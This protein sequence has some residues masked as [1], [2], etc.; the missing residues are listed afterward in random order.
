L[1]EPLDR[2]G[3]VDGEVHL[4]LGLAYEATGRLVEATDRAERSCAI[5]EHPTTLLLLA[6]LAR[7]TGATEEALRFCDR[8]ARTPDAAP[9][10]WLLRV[11]LLEEAGR[12]AEARSALEPLL[13]RHRSSPGGLPLAVRIEEAKLLVQEGL[14]RD[15]V[16]RIDEILA[17][18]GAGDELR[19]SMLYLKAKALDRCAAYDEAMEC[20]MRANDIGRIAFDPQ[21]YAEQVDA[22]MDNW[23]ADRMRRFPRSA[24]H[25]ER[26]VFVAGMPRSGTTLLDQIIDAHPMAAGVGELSSIEH[27]ALRLSSAYRHEL[28]APDCLGPFASPDALTAI[29]AEYADICA[30]KAPNAR[31]IVNKAL[32]NNRLVGLLAMLF[33]R[34]KV[35]HAIRDP[36]DVAVSCLMGGFNNALYPWTTRLDWVASAWE[37]SMRLMEH[38]KRVLDIEILEVRYERLVTHP[39][40]EFPRIVSFLGL[41]WDEQCRRFHESRRT[42]RTL[43]YDQ[44]N[45]P[46]Y[47]TSAGR[48]QRYA[49]HLEGMAWPAYG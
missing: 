39:D 9:P 36:R 38:W 24:C 4:L 21:I 12:T 44:V 23:S 29:A 32:G 1:L 15:A 3:I 26:P 19:R 41:P 10:A 14:H 2:P 18:C 37:Q 22:L 42:V 6:R 28:P 43:S 30:R 47:T 13:H 49:R 48:W 5:K 16:A 8:A 25:D 40:E 34:T 33:P 35:I 17:R 45:R 46:L 20:A 11:A 31:R 7:R 27:F